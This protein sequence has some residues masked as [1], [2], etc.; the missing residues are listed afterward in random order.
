MDTEKKKTGK[1]KKIIFGAAVLFVLF[2]I[3]S[4]MA[5][6]GDGSEE[7]VEN[8]SPADSAEEVKE[9]A[10]GYCGTIKGFDLDN[11]GKYLASEPD[12]WVNMNE[13]VLNVFMDIFKEGVS[14]LEYTVEGVDV[15]EEQEVFSWA[16]A[17]VRFRFLDYSGVMSDSL[18]RLENE[19]EADAISSDVSDEEI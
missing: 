14:N 12:Y 13:N 7:A 3:I 19:Y 5:G 11:T 15:D 17:S 8:A 4:S 6:G 9:L 16:N 1:L 18:E 10:E 2:I